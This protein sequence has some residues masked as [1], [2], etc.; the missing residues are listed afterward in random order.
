MS[1]ADGCL[2][3]SKTW[4]SLESGSIS[5]P[6][7]EISVIRV[8]KTMGVSLLCLEFTIE[9]WRDW[10]M[11]DIC[12]YIHIDML[13]SKYSIGDIM[14]HSMSKQHNTNWQFQ[15][16]CTTSNF[17]L[18]WLK[19]G[20]HQVW[21]DFTEAL[22]LDHD[23]ASTMVPPVH[24]II[25]MW[26]YIYIY[27]KKGKGITVSPY[28]DTFWQLPP[29]MW[30]PTLSPNNWISYGLQDTSKICRWIKSNHL[31]KFTPHADIMSHPKSL[32]TSQLMRWK[33]WR[34]MLPRFFRY[35]EGTKGTPGEGYTRPLVSFLRKREH[36]GGDSSNRLAN[37]WVPNEN[38]LL[39]HANSWVKMP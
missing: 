16:E 5:N 10:T 34:S 22:L 13:F 6:K 3:C 19:L 11:F 21:P 25:D 39:I 14:Y 36:C 32:L 12:T 33:T 17:G 15:R 2:L 28:S 20:S 38:P 24:Q 23:L 27:S 9:S 26:W 30:N 4:W 35:L 29:L 8:Q 7:R 18:N 1:S 31:Q 37:K